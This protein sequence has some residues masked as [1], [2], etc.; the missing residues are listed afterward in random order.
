MV[1]QGKMIHLILGPM[2]AGKTTQLL[3]L[4]ALYKGVLFDYAEFNG[5]GFMVSHRNQ[6]IPCLKRMTLMDAEWRTESTSFTEGPLFINEA[7][8][9][10]D[11]VEFVKKWELTYDI[12]LF[13]LDGDFKR[14][15]FETILQVLPLC[16]TVEKLQG[17]CAMCPAPSLFSKRIT[18]HQETYLLDESAYIPLCRNC[19][20]SY[21][22][23]KPL[24][25]ELPLCTR[26][27]GSDL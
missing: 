23:V 27:S 18:D 22:D 13:G 25:P 11:L 9:F 8:F 10:P 15:P 16:D 20:L 4:Y 19:Y 2:Y 21:S 5:E 1:D 26:L 12:Y 24:S 17:T 14:N 7:Q 3:D 6:S